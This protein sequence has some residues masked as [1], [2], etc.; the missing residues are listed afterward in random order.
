MR[1]DRFELLPAQR[2]LLEQGRPVEIGARALD[3]LC[4]LV[5]N[6]G[7][8]VS[9]DTLLDRV[10]RDVV[11]EE[12]NLHVQVSALRKLLG[13]A[14]I[15]TMPGRGYQFVL[16]VQVGLVS[17]TGAETSTSPPP[18]SRPSVPSAY[19]AGLS[20][21][22]G[23]DRELTQLRALLMQATLLTITGA[24]GSGKTLLARHL[25]HELR[26]WRP[27]G[28]TWVDL[29][30][31]QELGAVPGAVAAALG[32]EVGGTSPQALAQA[33]RGSDRLLVLD[34]AEH[35]LPAVVDVVRAVREAAPELR[36][37]VTSQAPLKL[38]DEKRLVLLGLAVPAWPCTADEARGFGA[39]AL[40]IDRARQ[41]DRRF[42][43]DAT[44]VGDVVAICTALDG[45]ALGLQLAASLLAMCPLA[46]VRR[47][48][49]HER[50]TAG[51]PGPAPAENVLGAAL[52]WS[53][54]LL[55]D[56][57]RRVFRRLAAALGPLPLPM[58]CA[59]V[60]DET[61]DTTAA[62]DALSDLVDRS[63]VTCEVPEGDESP[64]Y[65]L[66]DAPR[67]LALEALQASGEAPTLRARLAAEVAALAREAQLVYLRDGILLAEA[68]ALGDWPAAADVQAA[69]HW[70]LEHD[71]EAAA[72]IARTAANQ[73]LP[74]S[75]RMACAARLV[76]GAT[77]LSAYAAGEALLAAAT[78]TKH[79]DLDRRRQLFMQAAERY[80]EA[81]SPRDRYYALARAAEAA[82]V[83]RTPAL[84]D[85]PLAQARALEDPSWP[86]GLRHVLAAA[87]AALVSARDD[88]H[89]AVPAW[90]RALELGRASGAPPL[91]VLVSLADAE[92]TVGQFDAAAAHLQEA[93]ELTQR[94][95]RLSDRWTFIL[96]NLAAA[97]LLQGDTAGAR[98]AA[99]EAWPH[100]RGLDADA[101]WADHLAL[102]AAREARP[103]TAVL[104]LGLADAAYLRIRDGRHQL[105]ARHATLAAEAAREALGDARFEAL[106]IAG[107]SADSEEVVQRAALAT[108][109][110]A[111]P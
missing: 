89:A 101:W 31:V 30:E 33:L 65:R 29:L 80:A 77:G 87:E 67:A 111:W 40:F 44:T 68:V 82:A 88:L 102:L 13:R 1:F 50:P 95:G 36:V 10:W 76:D 46:E 18:Q 69:L 94:R 97:R 70:A 5:E 72:A 2:L 38:P 15:A 75:E 106:R 41:V 61:L 110:M 98:E 42:R 7:Q 100:A 107:S 26:H 57:P 53:H 56:E 35:L 24:G 92:L 93:A 78:L 37:L 19:A 105:E 21:M 63:L 73:Q 4:V 83:H 103:H 64:R 91:S 43:L 59:V 48:L 108:E 60:G 79:S 11:V 90:R 74:A 25:M 32:F 6:A 12:A 16:P 3:L 14:A 84:A 85:V 8:L 47:R 45:S 22:L 96:P 104:L 71:L 55:A 86:A 66:L 99:A 52:A 62:A 23:R 49:V 9:K 27:Q 81:G 54:G 109:D 51:E 20:A 28:V 17:A 39:V 58:L 34:N